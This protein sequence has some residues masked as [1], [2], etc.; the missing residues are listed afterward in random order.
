MMQKPS[1][2]LAGVSRETL[3]DLERFE[4]LFRGF[5]AHTNL[6]SRATLDAFWT[7]HILDSAQL[8]FLKPHARHWLDLGSGGGL[9]GVVVAILSKQAAEAHVDLVESTGKKAAFLQSVIDQLS[10]PARVHHCRIE[11]AENAVAVPEFISA[12]ALAPLP[13]LLGLAAPWLNRGATGLFHKGQNFRAEIEES[14][15]HWRFSVL[16]HQ[17]LTD[18]QSAILEIGDL[19]RL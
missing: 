15:A 11:S 7:R 2:V 13:K 10:L 16:E 17:S 14:R 12:R 18:S 9:P 5:A 4:S 8:H 19:R 1:A 6:A 3:G